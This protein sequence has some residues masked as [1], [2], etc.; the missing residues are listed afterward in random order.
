MVVV[1]SEVPSPMSPSTFVYFD[2]FYGSLS[3]SKNGTESWYCLF[4]SMLVDV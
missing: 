3:L 1:L 4:F 2:A